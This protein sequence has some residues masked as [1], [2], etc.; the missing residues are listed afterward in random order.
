MTVSHGDL[1]QV[2]QHLHDDFATKADKTHSASNCSKVHSGHSP[3]TNIRDWKEW[4][5]DTEEFSIMLMICH[6]CCLKPEVAFNMLTPCSSVPQ[7]CLQ[8]ILHGYWLVFPSF[9]FL[10]FHCK[11]G[12]THT[13]T[14]NNKTKQKQTKKKTTNNISITYRKSQDSKGNLFSLHF[15]LLLHFV[16]MQTWHLT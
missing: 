10:S 2:L 1:L 11:D 4:G 14:D 12:H 15:S 8:M 13:H 16:I 7:M 6:T 9:V 3:L 5:S